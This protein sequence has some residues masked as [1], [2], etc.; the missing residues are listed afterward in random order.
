MAFHSAVHQVGKDACN[1]LRVPLLRAEISLKHSS[2]FAG[3][4]RSPL[5]LLFSAGAVEVPGAPGQN[6]FG[7]QAYPGA[8]SSLRIRT[9]VLILQTRPITSATCLYELSEGL[10]LSFMASQRLS[11]LGLSKAI[12]I[13]QGDSCLIWIF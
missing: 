11:C 9:V 2:G 6:W 7:L 8:S 10:Q 4:I 13:L 12:S 3:V 5:Q 1:S